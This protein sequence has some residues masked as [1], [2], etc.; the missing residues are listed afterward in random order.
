M[1]VE[2]V[3]VV[4]AVR[5]AAEIQ[6]G[7]AERNTPVPEKNRIEFR[8]VKDQPLAHRDIWIESFAG[9][10]LESATDVLEA[11][12]RQCGSAR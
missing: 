2:F 1:L 3:S 4:D 12:R 7:M 5:C 11:T 6:R 9:A 10:S 8:I